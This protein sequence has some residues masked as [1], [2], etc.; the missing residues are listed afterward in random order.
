MDQNLKQRLVGAIV[1][2]SLAV[3]FLPLVFDGQQQR[4]HTEDYEFPEEPVITIE[5]D[6]F[7]RLLQEG[8]AVAEAVDAVEQAKS[9][10]EAATV[11][12][13]DSTA[14]AS[15]ANP[16]P[17]T[18]SP[19]NR[20]GPDTTS[21]TVEQYVREELEQA[22]T[23][24]D[25]ASAVALADAWMLQVGAFSSRANAEGLRDRLIAAGYKAYSKPVGEL[26][27]VYVG[28]EIRRYRLQ[29]QKIALEQEFKV[30]ALILK[31]IP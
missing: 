14:D 15:A 8:E 18:S 10:V 29:Q 4:I 27:K 5:D 16:D 24:A 12:A 26:H 2:I 17:A 3:I 11:E 28:P 25:A 30:N 6:D 20:S 31:Y 13:A 7:E 23:D 22:D 19:D 9:E 1:L 21:E